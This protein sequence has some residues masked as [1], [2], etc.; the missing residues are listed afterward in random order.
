MDEISSKLIAI[1][2]NVNDWLKF[3]EAKNGILL[4][5]SGAAITATITILGTTQSIPNSLK[6]G[7][8]LTTILLCLCSLICSLSFLPKTNLER[9]LPLN[10]KPSQNDNLWFYGS[11]QKYTPR[12]LLEALD[13]HYFKIGSNIIDE[14]KYIDIVEQ[15]T[16]NSRIAFLKYQVFTYALYLL[17]ASILVIPCSILISLITFHRL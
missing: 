12:E 9:V 14:K 8:F 5:F 1:F 4:A 11:L 3:A 10:R 7:L 17:I 2:Q 16:I 6:I 13:Q 15:I